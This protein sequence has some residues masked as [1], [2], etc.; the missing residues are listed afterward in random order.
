M[1]INAMSTRS[2]SSRLRRRFWFSSSSLIT[3]ADPRVAACAPLPFAPRPRA[4]VSC[5]SSFS[6]LGSLRR[7]DSFSASEDNSRVRR[8]AVAGS[9]IAS[10]RSSA[11]PRHARVPSSVAKPFALPM[12]PLA[13]VPAH[14]ACS[15]VS[16]GL[17]I[18]SA[19]TTCAFVGVGT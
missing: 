16:S 8:Y 11:R 13:M 6:S 14:S 4:L 10:T 19:A 5:S 3:P 7:F 18:R 9:K 2:N 1:S 15:T 12:W 17:P